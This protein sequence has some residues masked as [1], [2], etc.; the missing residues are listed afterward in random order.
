MKPLTTALF[1][2]LLPTC[3]FAFC[4]EEAGAAYGVSPL[5]LWSIAKHESNLNPRAIGRNVNGTYDY[6]L[7]QINSTWAGAIG[8]D[9]WRMLGDPCTNVKTG[10]WI[11]SRC[12][13]RHG[14]NWKAV[15][16]Y[17]SNTPGKRE[18][19]AGRIAAVLK[20][21]TSLSSLPLTGQT[22]VAPETVATVNPWQDVFGNQM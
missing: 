9:R 19:Y 10:A 7:M 3:T 12:I 13:R 20:Q 8:P 11:L 14:Y 5:L 15:G 4:F 16:C 17:N 22:A 18:R 6:G 21:A 2:L 1:L